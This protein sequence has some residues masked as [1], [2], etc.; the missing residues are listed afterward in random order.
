MH[1]PPADHP[2]L[3]RPIVVVGAP[4]SGTTILGSLLGTHPDLTYLEEPRLTWKFGNDRRSDMLRP[5]H[6][7]PPVVAHIRRAFARRVAEGGGRRLLEKTPS[8]ALRLGFVDAVLPDALYVHI[9][10]DGVESVLSIAQFWGRHT[11]GIPRHKLAQRLREHKPSRL[12]HYGKEVLRRLAPGLMGG[13][14]PWGPRLPGIEAMARELRPLEVAALQW[15]TCV[16]RAVDFGRS[17]P[18][19]RYLQLRLED[20]GV[21]V[22]RRI[23]EFVG[24]PPSDAV[25]RAIDEQF[26][27]TDPCRRRAAADPADVALI[28]IWIAPTQRW[29][30]ETDGNASPA[31][32]SI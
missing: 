11:T 27:P 13:A 19:D 20:L 26:R 4:R 8:N 18:P 21:E 16:E 28:Q 25:D 7:T 10:R 5:E 6:A 23:V 22:A 2:A 29:L 30:D 17:L 1:T 15:R 12:P 14:S 24:L 32:R 3:H 31:L 9:L